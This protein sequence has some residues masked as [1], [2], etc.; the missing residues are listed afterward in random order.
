MVETYRC[1]Y[2]AL[3]Y[4][5]GCRIVSLKFQ[6]NRKKVPKTLY[7]P[8]LELWVNA[9]G[10]LSTTNICFRVERLGRIIL[11]FYVRLKRTCMTY[12]WKYLIRKHG[13]TIVWYSIWWKNVRELSSKCIV[14]LDFQLRGFRLNYKI[15]KGSNES[16]IFLPQYSQDITSENRIWTRYVTVLKI[17]GVSVLFISQVEH[18]CLQIDRIR[19]YGTTCFKLDSEINKTF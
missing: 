5:I 16:Y 15:S 8:A 18:W 1:T 19:V 2:F 13:R 14:F 3:Y 9:E 10:G 7:L 17:N 4:V 12:I 6:W 11:C